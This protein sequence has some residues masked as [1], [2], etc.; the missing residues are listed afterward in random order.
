MFYYRLYYL[1]L[2]FQFF[3]KIVEGNFMTMVV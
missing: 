3:H 2:L 1:Q